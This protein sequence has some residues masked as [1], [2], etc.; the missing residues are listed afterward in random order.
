MKKRKNE[1]EVVSFKDDEIILEEDKQKLKPFAIFFFRYGRLITMLI[2]SISILTFIGAVTLT[3]SNLPQITPPSI[4]DPSG[5]GTDID[6]NIIMEFKSGDNSI[7]NLS[8]PITK[9]YAENLFN[10]ITNKEVT[11][12]NILVDKILVNEDKILIFNNGSAVIIYK[13]KDPIYVYNKNNIKVE[14]NKVTVIGESIKTVEK[15]EL[16]DKTIIYEFENGKVLIKKEENYYLMNKEDIKY[17]QQGN[18]K[19][20]NFNQDE[21]KIT[22]FS[23]S[24]ESTIQKLKY[25]VV[26]E[27]TNDYTEYNRQRLLP[28]YIYYKLNINGK[29]KESKLLNTNIWNDEQIKNNTYILYEGELEASKVDNFTLGLWVDYETIP[30]SMQNKS[31][32]GTI[33]VYAWE[34]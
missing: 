13:D 34:E 16:P 8:I 19:D 7:D 17:D 26:I 27:E 32:I 24:N 20:D 14:N 3:L 6:S 10:N 23:I 4:D 12:P 18:I 30:N 2:A 28:Q 15:K 22:D 9:E 33:K 5:D 25:R 21:L 31:F 1:F 29:V 11:L